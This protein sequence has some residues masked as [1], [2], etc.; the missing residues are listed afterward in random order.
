MGKYFNEG[1]ESKSHLKAKEKLYDLIVS[2]RVEITDQ[3]GNQYEIFNGKRNDE[4]LHIESF[5]MDYSPNVIFSNKE[6]PCKKYFEGTKKRPSCDMK[7]YF[8]A[9]KELPCSTCIGCNFKRETNTSSHLASFRPD[10]AF[11]YNG[12]HK[13]WFEIKNS[14]PCSEKKIEFCKA[15]G[16]VLLEI[17][18][19]DI[20]NFKEFT[21]TLKFNKLEEYVHQTNIYDDLKTIVNYVGEQLKEKQYVDVGEVLNEFIKLPNVDKANTRQL[22]LFY[23]KI[24]EKFVMLNLDNKIAKDHFGVKKKM[25][26]FTTNTENEL[27]RQKL[28]SNQDGNKK[29]KVKKTANG[30][31]RKV[32]CH[33]CREK[34]IVDEMVRVE[35]ESGKKQVVRYYHKNC[36]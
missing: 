35:A 11:G 29:D 27:L 19:S 10:V 22:M 3:Y 14:S 2:K 1:N 8:G 4:F 18:D 25:S 31:V 7:G 16:I 13:V 34:E 23:K 32:I 24:K 33:K 30:K 17:N 6:T 36:L 28:I 20:N 5:V 15:N 9:F 21:G 26:I 12:L